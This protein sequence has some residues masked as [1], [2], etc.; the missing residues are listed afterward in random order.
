MNSQTGWLLTLLLL[1]LAACG[2]IQGVSSPNLTAVPGAP[3]TAAD[4]AT[5]GRAN[6]LGIGGGGG[7]GGGGGGRN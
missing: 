1:G 6:D 2:A 3:G 5:G 7:A 4:M